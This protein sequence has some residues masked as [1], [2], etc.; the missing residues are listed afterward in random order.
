[1]IRLFLIIGLSIF[2]MMSSCS[3][4]SNSDILKAEWNRIDLSK[5]PYKTGDYVFLKDSNNYY[6]GIILDFDKDSAGIWIGICFTDYK[7]SNKPDLESIY[8]SRI[9]GRQ[10][11]NG[12]INTT[13]IDCYDLAYL[14]EKG[15]KNDF[16][17]FGL[18]G[19]LTYNNSKIKIGAISASSDIHGL[20][21]FYNYGITQRQKSPDDCNKSKF[22]VNAVIER[23]FT[24]NMMK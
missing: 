10:I 3:S 7:R 23:F 17:N 15:L 18:I 11:P 13:C 6:T 14:N 21:S 5:I 16:A 24:Y 9:F 4:H 8:E 20:I 12:L 19:K 1:M 2:A 22:K